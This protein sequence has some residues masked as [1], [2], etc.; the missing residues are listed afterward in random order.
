MNLFSTTE[1]RGIPKSWPTRG[2]GSFQPEA[3]FWREVLWSLKES[4]IVWTERRTLWRASV[5]NLLRSF[6]EL[7]Y[8]RTLTEINS[9][10][11]ETSLTSVFCHA[12]ITHTWPN[13]AAE[14]R[15]AQVS[16]RQTMSAL[17][18]YPLLHTHARGRAPAHTKDSLRE[19][20]M[21]WTC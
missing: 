17:C 14:T 16:W 10:S 13:L 15:W 2:A 20:P 1:D 8:L 12:R 5:C 21:T 3:R 18:P 19:L 6:R 11:H 9:L 4:I 7:L